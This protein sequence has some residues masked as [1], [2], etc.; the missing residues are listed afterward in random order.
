MSAIQVLCGCLAP[1]LYQ[2]CHT[3]GRAV[4]FV[5]RRGISAGS[6]RLRWARFV[7]DRLCAATLLQFA[8]RLL[9][10]LPVA[11]GVVVLLSDILPAEFLPAPKLLLGGG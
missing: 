1:M 8:V 4:S 9:V 2:Y 10:V 11:A 6:P 5:A 3:A 7:H